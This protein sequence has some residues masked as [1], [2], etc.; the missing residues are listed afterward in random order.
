MGRVDGT[1]GTRG[2]T[3]RELRDRSA[4]AAGL[5]VAW[6]DVHPSDMFA[7]E[8]G[9]GTH[10]VA[11]RCRHA[12][13][14]GVAGCSCATTPLAGTMMV[15]AVTGH[16]EPEWSEET[17]LERLRGVVEWSTRP[18]SMPEATWREVLE[19][20][21]VPPFDEASFRAWCR[22]ASAMPARVDG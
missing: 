9:G 14:G 11:V 22:E 12:V 7:S 18:A 3:L 2:M 17:A 4:K 21:G 6:F 20:A 10:G 13:R 16:E 15:G 8:A 1:D 19:V 5:L